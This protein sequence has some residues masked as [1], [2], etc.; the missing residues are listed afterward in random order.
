MRNTYDAWADDEYLAELV[1]S[2]AE[3]PKE[4]RGRW[5]RL[6]GALVSFAISLA[7]WT[8]FIYAALYVYHML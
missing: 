1:N 7:F 4:K 3:P 8:A 5:D 2:A 6:I